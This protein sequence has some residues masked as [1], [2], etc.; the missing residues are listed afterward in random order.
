MS[1]SNIVFIV[2]IIVLLVLSLLLVILSANTKPRNKNDFIDIYQKKKV[3]FQL[4]DNLQPS[5]YSTYT[6][7]TYTPP[8][9]TPPAYTP[10]S[11]TYLP[12]NDNNIIGSIVNI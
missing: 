5:A 10:P 3:T 9:Y 2:L 4:D 1:S 7:P 8:A 6:P 11:T 12:A